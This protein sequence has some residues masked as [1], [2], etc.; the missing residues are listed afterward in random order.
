MQSKKHSHLETASNQIIGIIIGW[1]IVFLVT[2]LLSHLNSAELATALTPMFFIASYSRSYVLRRVFNH[3]A[4]KHSKEF[5]TGGIIERPYPPLRVWECGDIMPLPP[6][7]LLSLDRK[8]D[9]K[10]KLESIILETKEPS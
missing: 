5:A 3:K 2:P 4:I 9:V 10:K 8:E 7:H 6:A 1:L